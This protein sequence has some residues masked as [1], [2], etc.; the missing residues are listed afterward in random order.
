MRVFLSHSRKDSELVA[1]TKAALKILDTSAIALEDLPGSRTVNDARQEIE[2]QIRNS[3]IVFLLLTPNAVATMHTRT[4]IG[5][6]VAVASGMGKE[7]AV[8]Q[9]P[10]VPP[11]WPV[12]YWSDLVVLSTDPGSRP[13]QLQRVVKVL[14]PSAAPAGGAA[15]GAL[16]GAIFGPVGL[17]IGLIIGGAAGASVVPKKP[18]TLRCPKC[19]IP[20][21][22]WN[23]AGSAF[24]CPH[25]FKL[26]RYLPDEA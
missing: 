23:P 21:R 18:P 16:A 7:L 8:F 11:T 2:R 15:G 25:C 26:L 1:R 14:K 3:E 19:S 10:G 17:V 24:Y 20:F 12:T 13:I 9:E 22:F 5:H 6:E 4:W